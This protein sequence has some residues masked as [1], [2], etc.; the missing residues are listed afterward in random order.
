MRIDKSFKE[1]TNI[2]LS[3]NSY[4][5][6]FDLLKNTDNEYFLNIFKSYLISNNILDNSDFFTVYTAEHTDW[7]ENI[8][9]KHYGT[10]LLWWLVALTNNVTNPFEDMYEGRQ[11]KILKQ[12]YIYLIFKD[13]KK[14]YE[15]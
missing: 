9:D 3:T 10:P 8:S 6:M 13:L 4:L 12:S 1:I 7:W 15:I 14:I 11:I 5:N 2:R